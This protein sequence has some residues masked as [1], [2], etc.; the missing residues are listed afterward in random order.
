[1]QTEFNNQ[2]AQ[3]DYSNQPRYRSTR[4]LKV[5]PKSINA[6]VFGIVSIIG[7]F[8]LGIPGFVFA[9]IAKKATREAQNHYDQNPSVYKPGSYAFVKTGRIT[10]TI[11]LILSIFMFF[12][13]IAYFAFIIYMITEASSH[14]Y[15]Y[16]Y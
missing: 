6:M 9:L 3:Y 12:F 10:S 7:A 5:I 15:D 4:H 1:M 8:Q 13:W 2:Q 16:Y 14:R 11:G